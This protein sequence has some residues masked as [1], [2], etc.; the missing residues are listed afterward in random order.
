MT[1]EARANVTRQITKAM[2]TGVMPKLCLNIGPRTTDKDIYQAIQL[3][4]GI[5][6][7]LE[8]TFHL[9]DSDDDASLDPATHATLG[10]L[11]ICQSWLPNSTV[12][13]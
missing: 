6:K 1:D 4:A 12:V 11:K 13:M 2:T 10:Y 7:V 8:V 9:I 5:N 3:I